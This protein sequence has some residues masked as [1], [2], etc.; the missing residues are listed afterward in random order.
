MA[1]RVEQWNKYINEENM[2]QLFESIISTSQDGLY[3]CDHK[4][5]TL[6]VNDAL[7]NVTN[8][9]KKTFFSY[10][11]GDLIKKGILPK[12]CAYTTLQ[13]KKKENMIIHYHQGKK[14]VLT[15]TPVFDKDGKLFCIVSN[16]RDITELKNLHEQL[17]ES[18]RLKSE[19]EELLFAN[20]NLFLNNRLPFIYKSSEMAD[21]IS[22]SNKLSKTDSPILILG[23]SGS[24]KDVLARY[25]HK[26]SNR[27]GDFV[28]INC[29]AIPADLIES[30]LFGY[31]QGA[32]TG[33][34][35]TKR[36]LFEQSDE[37]TIF[38]DEIG[39]MPLE[40]Q[41]KLLSVIEDKK[42]R[43]IGGTKSFSIKIRIIA[44][45]N[46]DLANMVE[47]KMFRHDLYYRLNVLPI[48]IPPL[49]ERKMDI[50]IL[51]LYFLNKLNK[52]YHHD[53]QID[54]LI[55][56]NFLAY[57][58]PGNVRELKNIVERM[59]HMSDSNKISTNYIPET[60]RD[61]INE[62]NQSDSYYSLLRTAPNVGQPAAELTDV[63]PLDETVKQF[64]K[65]YIT[66]AIHR[67]DTLKETA[68]ALN[69]SL[70]T[71][72]RKRREYNITQIH[73]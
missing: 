66:Q 15:S 38:L 53:K 6:L 57:S 58:W 26:K 28:K 65:Q 24:G 23:E 44:A 25:I 47:Q 13:T 3:I 33:A 73:R 27:D 30:E 39:E 1:E 43:R 55:I 11:L 50:P 42:V 14:A 34:H 35:E 64:E 36:G 10:T 21:V 69:I 60:I 9:D 20:N 5:K 46:V 16:V 8:I 12:S 41:A 45:T 70:S 17:E 40:L 29:A 59:Y 71:L 52:K 48:T 7:I 67:H 51:T 63:L 56:D 37:G 68:E 22:L 4:G 54:P 2:V 32:F 62:M 61:E 19:Y 72:T 49:R 18:N 31:E